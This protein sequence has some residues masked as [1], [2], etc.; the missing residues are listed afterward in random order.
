M[1]NRRTFVVVNPAS[2]AGKGYRLWDQ[3]SSALK[4]SIGSFDFAFTDHPGHGTSLTR[5]ALRKGYDLIV[6]VGGDGSINEVVNGFFEGVQTISSNAVMGLI[7]TGTGSDFFRTLNM[8]GDLEDCC[9]RL[10]GDGNHRIDVGYAQFIDR[11]GDAKSR[12]FLNVLSLGCGGEVAREMERVSKIFGGRFAYKWASIKTLVKFKDKTVQFQFDGDKGQTLLVT[13]LSICNGQYFGGGMWV[14]PSARI[15]DGKLN[16][17]RWS[18]FT[19]MDFIF[20]QRKIYDGSHLSDPGTQ[21]LQLE[22]LIAESLETTLIEIDGEYV[23][24]LPLNVKL[25]PGSITIK[26]DP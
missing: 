8:S 9:A 6:A 24:T 23:G 19:L 14:S 25:L 17:T 7:P 26:T 15:D 18:G 12:I 11:Q 1:G 16:V 5:R 2:G 20:K 22:N 10:A 4:R 3:I 13:N 21:E